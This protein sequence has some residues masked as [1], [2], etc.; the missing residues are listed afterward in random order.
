M[1]CY[2]RSAYGEKDHNTGTFGDYCALISTPV[3][4]GH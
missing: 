4:V 1:Y 3:L 2:E